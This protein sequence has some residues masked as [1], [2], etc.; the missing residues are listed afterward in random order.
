M[1]SLQLNSAGM[2]DR[3]QK[4]AANEDTIL[5]YTRCEEPGENFGLYVVCDGLGGHQAGDVASQTA[6]RTVVQELQSILPPSPANHITTSADIN[7]VI[8]T[9]V[10][11]ANEAI[12]QQ[13]EKA[14]GPGRG[15]G[16]TL[17]MA[18]VIN[19]TVHMSATV[20]FISSG[21]VNWSS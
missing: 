12:W 3:G 7:H 6:V 18:V 16:T 4:R 9:A 8:W 21:R 14:D 15:M 13:A 5:N 19:D 10:Q 17:T 2:T 20:A 11:K 1:V